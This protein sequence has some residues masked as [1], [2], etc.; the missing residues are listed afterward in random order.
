MFRTW[1]CPKTALLVALL[2]SAAI[3]QN[4]FVSRNKTSIRGVDR[5]IENFHIDAGRGLDASSMGGGEERVGERHNQVG[6]LPEELEQAKTRGPE[7]LA[8]HDPSG[9]LPMKTAVV[10]SECADI[11]SATPVFPQ[12]SRRGIFTSLP[13]RPHV[14]RENQSHEKR[15]CT[16]VAVRLRSSPFE[17]S[18]RSCPETTRPTMWLP[19]ILYALNSSS[20]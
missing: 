16:S 10:R 4:S 17:N 13:T 1:L 3:G 15:F 5:T 2:S 9:T 12:K 14:A 6:Q 20:S 18:T 19:K 8:N 11:F 7:E